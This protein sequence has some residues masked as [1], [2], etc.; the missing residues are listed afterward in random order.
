MDRLYRIFAAIVCVAGIS[1]Y[2]A[3]GGES[4]EKMRFDC[5]NVTDGLSQMSVVT[6]IQDSEGFMWFGTRDGLNRYDGYEFKVFVND[7]H[8]STTISD[9]YI[10]CA[11]N[12]SEGRLW[13]GTTNGVNLYC[14]ETGSFRRWYIDREDHTGNTNEINSL[15]ADSA[16]GVWVGTYRG[17]Y[18]ISPDDGSGLASEIGAFPGYRIYSMASD[19]SNLYIGHDRGLS[20]LSPDGSLLDMT[21][22]DRQKAVN[23]VFVDS[24]GTLRFCL[25]NS[26]TLGSIEPGTGS[27]SLVQIISDEAH[28][29]NN[30]IRSIAEQDDGRFVLGTYDGLY[31]YN[32]DG[33]TIESYN[34]SSQDT[35]GLSHYAVEAVYIDKENTLWVGTYAGGVN[36][37]HAQN[38]QFPF[39]DP[40]Q[41]D[42]SPGVL[43]AIA[44]EPSGK[45]L[46]IGSD[47]GGV[48]RFDVGEG[49]FEYFPCSENSSDLFKDNNVKSLHV[50]GTTLYV[51]LYTGQLYTMDT[52]TCRRTGV[53]N[54]PEYTA[55]YAMEE[56]G[57]TL[58]LGT[59]SAHG[60]KYLS[61]QGIR[62]YDLPSE[63]KMVNI[64]QISCLCVAGEEI[65]VGTR[66]SGLYRYLEDGRLLHYTSDDGNSISGNRITTIVR[67]SRGQ[68]MIGTS[69]GGLNIFSPDTGTFRTISGKDGLK[70]NTICSIVEDR[71]GH[72]WVITRTSISELADGRVARTYDHSSGI[73]IQEFSQGAAYITPDNTIWVG[74]NNGMISFNPDNLSV[75]DYPSPVVITSVS[76]NN[77]PLGNPGTGKIRLRH[78]ENN[79]TF[80][81]SIL[82][83]IY[84]K[85]NT[86]KY[87]LEGADDGWKDA[88]TVREV[89]YANLAPG[90]Y[91]F[92]VKGANNDGIWSSSTASVDVRIA[93]PAW[94]RWWAFLL[95]T[96]ISAAAVAIVARYI[97]ERRRLKKDVVMKQKQEELYKSRIDLFT[98]FAHE[99]RTPLSLI[100][101]PLEEMLS[102]EREPGTEEDELRMMYTN[103]RR[104][105]LIINQLMDI[106][107]KDAKAM[108]LQVS[109]NDLASFAEE[110]CNSFRV[111]A[112][113]QGIRYGFECPERPLTAW[114]DRW[115]FD[116]VLMNL[117]S[118]AFKYTPEGGEIV[119]SAERT[120]IG[121]IPDRARHEDGM[122]AD[123]GSYLHLSVKDSG[124]GIKPWDME[125]IFDPFY[126]A[127][128]ARGVGTG[129]GLSLAKAIVEM[130]HGAIWAESV[131]GEGS[132]FHVVIPEGHAHFR[133]EEIVSK[134]PETERPLLPG[135]EENGSAAGEDPGNDT[136]RKAGTILIVE[137]N[138][139]LR[140]YI[141]KKLQ[142]SWNVVEAD[143]GRSGQALALNKMPALVISDVMMPVMD[144]MQ[145]CY[146]LKHDPRTA[147]IPVILLT[148]KNFEFQMKEGLESGADDYITKPFRMWE[149]MLKV[150]NILSSRSSLKELYGEKLSMENLGVRTGSADEKFLRQLNDAI[151]SDISNPELNLDNLC[152]D[153][154]M[155][156]AT[157]YRKLTAATG[158]TPARYL[159]QVRLNLAAKMLRETPMRV[160]EVAEATGFNSL[161]HFSTLFR[162]QYGVP[163]SK[164][165]AGKDGSQPAGDQNEPRG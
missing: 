52:R 26:G 56:K 47:A 150:R 156:R 152:R 54:N 59:Y 99:L 35:G 165:A 105:M 118:N 4:A 80:S 50:D 68:V 147:H 39:Y 28:L 134:A 6:I 154:G 137:D 89:T 94:L 65:W 139:Q 149:L 113:K 164:Y 25:A 48:L 126:R 41:G 93:Y 72:V 42:F 67:D 51:G 144:G 141:R 5:L 88:G 30:L 96:L 162:K 109:E 40:A 79:I 120:D 132:V 129:I 37:A 24:G 60:L 11:V 142:G 22:T 3:Q 55:I 27:C 159:N 33:D 46:W 160:S 114:F 117:L 8:D 9:N 82:N 64:S 111:Q 77:R 131:T 66:S 119:L 136:G 106:R 101:S 75:N 10:K 57:D 85:R 38:M 19:G 123:A 17:L 124:P 34:Y 73:R 61:P 107:S 148:A 49:S 135:P 16:G 157:L 112:G 7:L 116:K 115:L 97:R 32:P 163:P 110:I 18:H 130:H 87:R 76:V 71:S 14:P 63:G 69:D 122:Y 53:W 23:L 121:C 20:M 102:G 91:H 127:S 62:Y 138:A 95:Y 15:C 81:F 74:G 92:C 21:E 133:D 78:N 83:Y 13:V 44:A 36:Y 151:S 45:V 155:S 90:N 103:A 153:I 31:I 158:L 43:S 12:D 86:Y 84:P 161:I 104:M 143:N 29:R 125:R 100:I 70:D 1:L 98:N 145:M 108:T 146:N 2:G 58:L 128:D 140:T